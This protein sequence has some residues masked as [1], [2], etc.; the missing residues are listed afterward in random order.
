MCGVEKRMQL[1]W[2]S[3]T[4]HLMWLLP[5]DTSTNLSEFESDNKNLHSTE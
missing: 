5:F 4:V 2:Y 3:E 1:I